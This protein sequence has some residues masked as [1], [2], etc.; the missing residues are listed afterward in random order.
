MR[1]TCVARLI[2]IRRARCESVSID[3]DTG[4]DGH[5][6]ATDESARLGRELCTSRHE[7]RAT[8]NEQ[9]EE[10]KSVRVMRM[11]SGPPAVDQTASRFDVGG[12]LLPMNSVVTKREARHYATD[13]PR[14][15]DGP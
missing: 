12:T 6:A 13:D 8:S 15:D 7:R 11:E 2:S 10:T 3:R 14:H 1:S 9:H 4:R 5:L